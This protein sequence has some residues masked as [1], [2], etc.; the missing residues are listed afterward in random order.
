MQQPLPLGLLSAAVA[1][2]PEQRS[3]QADAWQ[4]QM[5][6]PN[7]VSDDI[8][9]QQDTYC[10]CLSSPTI[11]HQQLSILHLFKNKPYI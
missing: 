4:M 11:W 3:K 8:A 1:E 9:S 2:E 5:Q 6:T 7:H 10:L